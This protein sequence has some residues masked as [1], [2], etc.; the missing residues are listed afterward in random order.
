MVLKRK[1]D[2][3]EKAYTE[4]PRMGSRRTRKEGEVQGVRLVMY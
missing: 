2:A 3:R 4:T 1:E